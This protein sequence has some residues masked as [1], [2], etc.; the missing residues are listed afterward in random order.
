[1]KTSIRFSIATVI[2][3]AGFLL[4]LCHFSGSGALFGLATFIFMPRSE[5]TRPVPRHELWLSFGVLVGLIALIVAAKYFVPRSA[6]DVME[7]IISHPAV[8]AP[9]WLLTLW[10]LFRNWQRQKRRVD[11]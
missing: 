9:L 10:A 3:T 2:I 8:L 1:M 5:L 11:A 6:S 7:R 4:V